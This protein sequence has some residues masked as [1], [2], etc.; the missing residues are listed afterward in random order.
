[1]PQHGDRRISAI[2]EWMPRLD[3]YSI[4]LNHQR[5]DRYFLRQDCGCTCV[6][7]GA[8]RAKA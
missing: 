2:N 3:R 6:E 1:V 4:D 8:G 5:S 7:S